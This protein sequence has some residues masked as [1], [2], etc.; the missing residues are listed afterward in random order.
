MTVKRILVKFKGALEETHKM[1]LKALNGS[2][3]ELFSAWSFPIESYDSLGRV[4]KEMGRPHHK[5][6]Y[7][8]PKTY[9]QRPKRSNAMYGKYATLLKKVTI[10]ETRLIGDIERYEGKRLPSKDE[11]QRRRAYHFFQEEPHRE[12]MSEI[13]YQVENAFYLK[14]KE[15]AALR[16][17]INELH[18]ELKALD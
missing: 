18:E 13:Q 6:E 12:G 10:E 2:W 17:E 3:D 5:H 16:R 8:L 7:L 1:A 9:V 4:L 15:L 14:W 11:D